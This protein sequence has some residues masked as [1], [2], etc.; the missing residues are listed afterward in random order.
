MPVS[1]WAWLAVAAFVACAPAGARAALFLDGVTTLQDGDIILENS[2]DLVSSMIQEVGRPYGIYTHATMYLELPKAGGRVISFS[3]D[4]LTLEDPAKISKDLYYAALV[5]PVVRP[6]A[7]AL[8]AAF[9]RIAA[10]KPQFDY[11]LQWPETNSQKTDCLGLVSQTYRV[12]GLPD[13]FAPSLEKPEPWYAWAKGYYGIDFS[14][15]MSP[16]AALTAK[17]FRVVATYENKDPLVKRQLTISQTALDRIRVFVTQEHMVP[18]AR[19][20]DNLALSMAGV[21]AGKQSA[22]AGIPPAQK[23]IYLVLQEYLLAV[24]ERVNRIID[25]SGRDWT[26]AQTA[27]LTLKV[28]DA[29]R[30]RFLQ[31]SQQDGWAEKKP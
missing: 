5:R 10:R 1:K 9:A 20:G 6:P 26:P 27:A 8:G 31:L 11:S 2:G 13:P 16:N 25:L 21:F 29:A 7:G 24:K 4:G 17:G 23:R 18:K 15:I 14:R 30:N 22:V 3:T 19:L 28:T 12:A